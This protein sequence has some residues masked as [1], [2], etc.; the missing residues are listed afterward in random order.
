[1][2]KNFEQP[3]M[4]HVTVPGGVTEVVLHLSDGR[5]KPVTIQE[6]D[7]EL[8]HK[9]AEYL[10]KVTSSDQAFLGFIYDIMEKKGLDPDDKYQFHAFLYSLN[11][12]LEGLLQEA[13]RR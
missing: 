9:C 7:E 12:R 10:E 4:L 2:P 1:M 6:R 11:T 8:E 5:C 3:A 13:G